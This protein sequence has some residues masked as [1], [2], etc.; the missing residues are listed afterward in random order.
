MDPKF[1]ST[2][3]MRDFPLDKKTQQST[4][5]DSPPRISEAVLHAMPSDTTESKGGTTTAKTP[6]VKLETG[7]EKFSA[8]IRSL[9]DLIQRRLNSGLDEAWASPWGYD[10]A[11]D[12]SAEEKWA[13]Q[14][15]EMFVFTAYE[16]QAQT[17]GTMP[18]NGGGRHDMEYLRRI[19][20]RWDPA[21]T[22]FG[23]CQHLCNYMV[24]TRGISSKGLGTDG[25]GAGQ[26]SGG[27][28]FKAWHKGSERSLPKL[29]KWLGDHGP[30]TPASMIV[31]DTPD[32]ARHIGGVL[33]LAVSGKQYQPMDTGVLS[34]R[35]DQGTVDHPAMDYIKSGKG[36]MAGIGVLKPGTP[37]E[38]F[39]ESL[40]A[41]RPLGFAHLIVADANKKARFIS[42]ALPMYYGETGFAVTRYVWSLRCLPLDVQAFWVIST[43]YYPIAKSGVAEL[44]AKG[45]RGKP[46]G[47]LLKDATSMK[48]GQLFYLLNVLGSTKGIPD[49]GIRS[50]GAFVYRRKY[51]AE[52]QW[53]PYGG[54]DFSFKRETFP[55]ELGQ[56]TAEG[57]LAVF[58]KW[59]SMKADEEWT[60]HD[61]TS[62][63]N[64]LITD[65]T[66][67]V[68]YFSGVQ[69]PPPLP[70][71]APR[72]DSGWGEWRA[73]LPRELK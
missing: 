52:D 13:R 3:V 12:T 55:G 8:A 5:T 67:G 46:L 21:Y 44:V 65:I 40:K 37:D 54:T 71:P 66:S 29:N 34:G 2:Q 19:E 47:A 24:V 49:D 6:L 60:L 70:P 14:F 68:T 26:M 63:S 4:G 18:K 7:K 43:F 25:L 22:P 72:V 27:D 36:N 73:P 58:K 15:A 39:V 42:R 9:L 23:A 56:V 38:K 17:F 45:S 41:A 69:P 10:G 62:T 32:P 16:G 59:S 11:L 28:A 53:A 30:L 31:F 61:P 50:A 51:K 20:D 33:R 64:N 35:G 57:D 48:N 1:Q